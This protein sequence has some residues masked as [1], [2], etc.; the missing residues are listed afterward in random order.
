MPGGGVRSSHAK[1]LQEQTGALWLHS[2][3]ITQGGEIAVP[4]EVRALHTAL[5]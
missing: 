1:E 3:A 2:S 5:I 4:E